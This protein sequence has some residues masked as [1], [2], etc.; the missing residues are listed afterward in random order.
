MQV[1]KFTF[2]KQVNIIHCMHNHGMSKNKYIWVGFD[3][4]VLDMFLSL[5]EYFKT[6]NP[7]Y[8]LLLYF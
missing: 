8:D 3:C 7:C 6:K 4:G 2:C 5:R 1:F